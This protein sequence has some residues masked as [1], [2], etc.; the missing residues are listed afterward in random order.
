MPVTY[1]LSGKTALVTGGAKGIG[2][3]VVERLAA[4]GAKVHVWDLNRGD[5]NSVTYTKVDVTKLNEINAAIAGLIAQEPRV[6]ILVND[7]GYLGRAVLYEDHDPSDWNRVIAINL[8]GMM[9]VTQ[10]LLPH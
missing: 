1:E 9:Q 2:K 5:L 7:A 10:A 4:S 6:D 8:L 3:A